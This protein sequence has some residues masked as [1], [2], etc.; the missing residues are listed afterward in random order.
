MHL[1]LFQKDLFKKQQRQLVIWSVIKLL[2]KLQKFQKIHNKE[3]RDR[4]TKEYIY[5]QKEDRHLLIIWD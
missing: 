1:K 3:I 5:F 4:K 2:I